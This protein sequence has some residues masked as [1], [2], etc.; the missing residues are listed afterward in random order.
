MRDAE[1]KWLKIRENT[2]LFNVVADPLER[3]N[4]RERLPRRIPEHG[5]R[6]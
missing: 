2:F 4:L 3:A 5:E 6:L 1:A